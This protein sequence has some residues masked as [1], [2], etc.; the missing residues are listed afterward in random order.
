M[1]EVH[2]EVD[3]EQEPGQHHWQ[4]QDFKRLVLLGVA[5]ISGNCL[6]HSGKW[7]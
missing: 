3:E 5:S 6:T 2:D 4:Q 7:K 1:K